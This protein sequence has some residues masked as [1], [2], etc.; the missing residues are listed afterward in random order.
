MKRKLVLFTCVSVFCV[1]LSGFFATG[2]QQAPLKKQISN[3]LIDLEQKNKIHS[4]EY[5][6][7]K[8]EFE[9]TLQY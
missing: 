8:K 7:T 2:S 9:K 1:S 6:Q 4:I 3:S 5:D